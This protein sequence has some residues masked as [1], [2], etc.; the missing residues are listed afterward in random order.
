MDTGKYPVKLGVILLAMNHDAAMLNWVS[1]GYSVC[2]F[3][4]HG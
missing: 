4:L 2:L 1:I 3:D